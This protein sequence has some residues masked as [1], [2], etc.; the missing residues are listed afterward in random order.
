MAKT[1]GGL[2]YSH[3]E[4]SDDYKEFRAYS[5]DWQKTYFDPDTGGFV[6]THKERIESGNKSPNEHEKFQKEQTMC[7]DLAEQGHKVEHLSD[8]G[9][10][11]GQTYDV[12]FDGEHADLKSVTSH[13]NIEKYVRHA[14]REQ[15]AKTVIVRVENS[16]KK[17]KA[18]KALHDSK[19][20]YGRKILYYFESD[21][22]LREV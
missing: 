5:R 18:V 12:N 15:G 7:K 11:K 10:K 4:P 2:R 19:R 14:V 21:K 13:N 8:N 6:V 20:K 17:G 3:A 9:R 22:K 16:A 1:S